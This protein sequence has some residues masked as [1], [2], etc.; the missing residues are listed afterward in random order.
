M[1]DLI[2]LRREDSRFREQTPEAWMAQSRERKFYL[3]YF[4]EEN[5][6]RLLVVNLGRPQSLEPIPEPFLRRRLD[7]NG[8]SLV[9]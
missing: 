7:S 2:R 9:E 5:D 4:A 6:D 8:T 1:C 3:R